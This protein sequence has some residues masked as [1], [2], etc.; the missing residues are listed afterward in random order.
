[1]RKTTS[2]TYWATFAYVEVNMNGLITAFTPR[3]LSHRR[4]DDK[5]K[6]N[7][8]YDSNV[9]LEF[10]VQR[11]GEAEPMKCNR[12]HQLFEPAFEG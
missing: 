9:G 4:K 8:K 2:L 3:R 7:K 11:L 6:Q 5:T 10:P 12:L 1:M